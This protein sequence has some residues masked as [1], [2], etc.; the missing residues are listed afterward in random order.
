MR[1]SNGS[2]SRTTLRA[3]DALNF[4]L[5][6]VRDGLGP[7]MAIYLI[8]KRHWDPSRVGIAMSAMLIGTVVAQTPA[9]ALIDRTRRKRLAGALAAG[10]GAPGCG[11]M[12]PR[13]PLPGLL[14]S[15]AAPR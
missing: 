11:P 9:G 4:F 15:P 1:E 2:P 7:Y 8:S 12:I 5:A 3:L 10:L 14:A 6:D 13:P